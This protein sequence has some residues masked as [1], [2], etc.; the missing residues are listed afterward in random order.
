ML[1]GG[2][3]RDSSGRRKRELGARNGA[4]VAGADVDS[5]LD[6]RVGTRGDVKVAS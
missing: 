6:D 4:V 2:E 1:A 5:T 3:S